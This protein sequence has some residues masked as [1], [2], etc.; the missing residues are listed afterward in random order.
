MY[1]P[2]YAHCIIERMPEVDKIM[3]NPFAH[4]EF[5]LSLRLKEGQKLKAESFDSCYVLPN[6]F[7][8]ALIPFFAGIKE[9]IGLKGESRYLLLNRMRRD[10]HNFARMVNRYVALAHIADPSVISDETLPAFAYPELK[11]TPP[12]PE[13]LAM[14]Q[15]DEK[16][17]L[18]ALGCGANYGPSKLWPAEYFA[19]VSA[20]FLKRGWAILALGTAKDQE[21]INAIKKALRGK[22][23]DAEHPGEELLTH[24]HDT[25]GKTSLT[26]AL[27]LLGICRAAVCN[28]S[29]MM[30]L[31]AA[32][33]VPQVCIFGSTSTLYTPPLS[34]KAVCLESTQPCHP[35][36]KR[37]CRFNTYLC[38]K[39]ILPERAVAALDGLLNQKIPT[40]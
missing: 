29:G 21:T 15:L 39:E 36:F 34:E 27:D 24:F 20:T 14:L 2:A 17:P 40:A 26:E 16:R 19:E 13:L 30:H 4:G 9:R 1:A 28:D 22:A 11:T 25:A 31:A 8:S 23:H 18:L 12:E 6:S 7:K 33:Q 10:K 32:A 35:C 37:T 38:Q 5:N 3:T